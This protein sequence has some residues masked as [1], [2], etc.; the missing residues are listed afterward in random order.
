MLPPSSVTICCCLDFWNS[1]FHVHVPQPRPF[2]H[3]MLLAP[4]CRALI[5][6][7]SCR[8]GLQSSLALHCCSVALKLHHCA[9]EHSSIIALLSAQASSCFCALSFFVAP[10]SAQLLCWA[11]MLNFFCAVARSHLCCAF[12]RSSSLIAAYGPVY[13]NRAVC[14]DLIFALLFLLAIYQ[15]QVWLIHLQ[16]QINFRYGLSPLQFALALLP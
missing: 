13:P 16:A 11:V 9:V 4:R 15:A 12:A 5:V 8:H 10:L 6:T 2:R 3:F 1:S 7:S 14:A